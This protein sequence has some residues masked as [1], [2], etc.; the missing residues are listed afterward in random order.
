MQFIGAGAT[1]EVSVPTDVDVK[2]IRGRLNMARSKFS[3][4]F[5]FSLDAVKHWDHS[6]FLYLSP[7]RSVAAG[8]AV[9]HVE[10]GAV[11]S[12]T[13]D[14]L[15]CSSP[16][17]QLQRGGWSKR[18]HAQCSSELLNA[19]RLE[20]LRKLRLGRWKYGR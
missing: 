2:A 18:F 1:T 10:H 7:L 12:H 15:S 14:M 11:R 16:A 5:G 13:P 17:E 19:D 3:D 6:G 20:K 8:S 9:D 4:I